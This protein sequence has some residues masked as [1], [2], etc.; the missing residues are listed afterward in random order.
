MWH[1]N[2]ATDLLC[3]FRDNE[4]LMLQMFSQAKRKGGV[5]FSSMPFPNYPIKQIVKASKYFTR[6]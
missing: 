3:Q 2:D 1:F 4:A 6:F 5:G